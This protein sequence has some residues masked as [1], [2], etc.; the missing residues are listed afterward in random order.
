MTVSGAVSLACR[1][2]VG[3]PRTMPS[4]WPAFIDEVTGAQHL[5]LHGPTPSDFPVVSVHVE[6]PM[7]DIFGSDSCACGRRLAEAKARIAVEGGL[8][9]YLRH[10]YCRDAPIP[11]AHAWTAGRR[12]RA[13]SHPEQSR[14]ERRSPAG[15]AG[16]PRSAPAYRYHCDPTR[17][18][19][20]Q[21]LRG[22]ADDAS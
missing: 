1:G 19:V 8:M 22:W 7:G 11:A 10:P 4:M 13:G 9:V 2:P 5:V 16:E 21:R 14:H 15:G 18:T 3:R 17:K 12:W 6:C 20:K